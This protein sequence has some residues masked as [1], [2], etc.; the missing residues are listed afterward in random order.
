MPAINN[1]QY[2]DSLTYLLD[3]N[4]ELSS[5]ASRYTLYVRW[6]VLVLSER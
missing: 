2:I 3:T 4:Y 5:E 1:Y 6:S